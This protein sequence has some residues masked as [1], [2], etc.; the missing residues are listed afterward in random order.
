MDEDSRKSMTEQYYEFE[1]GCKIKQ[2]GTDIKPEDGL[3]PLEVDFYNIDYNCPKV[4]QLFEDGKTKGV[5]QLDKGLGP[6]WS[7]QTKPR[8]VE[9]IA[10]LTSILR[11][12]CLKSIVDGKSV[13]QRYADRKAGL[14]PVKYIH[15]SIEEV[16]RPTYGNLVFQEQSIHIAKIV[17]GF[18]LQQADTLRK[19]IGKK[20]ADTMAK[21]RKEFIEGCTKTGIVDDKIAVDIFDNIEKSNRYAFNKSH[22]VG[23][24]E[25]SYWTAY[26]KVHFPIHFYAAWLDMSGEKINPKEEVSELVEDAKMFNVGIYPPLIDHENF[27]IT[28]TGVHFGLKQ[29]KGIGGSSVTKLLSAVI[30]SQNQL[31]KNIKDWTWF[32]LLVFLSEK[33]SKTVFNNLVSLGVISPAGMSRQ[34]MLHEYSLWYKLSD[35]EKRIIVENSG[36]FLGGL[37]YLIHNEKVSVKRRDVILSINESLR[38]P[39]YSTEDTPHWITAI[40]EEL[41][42]TPITCTKVDNINTSISDSTCQEFING[43]SE[44]EM[45]FGVEICRASEYIIKSGPNAGK[46]MAF[47]TVRDNSG[48][49]DATIFNSLWAKVKNVAYKGNTCLITGYRSDKGGLIIKTIREI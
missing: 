11:P 17:A 49:M 20:E 40:E 31:G 12:G 35:K 32:E 48:S 46:P 21:V 45:T 24:S 28:K 39:P 38:E 42:G 19:A 43:K 6:H 26:L 44:K 10:A 33:I 27:T 16:L 37:R 22:A 7:K 9:E 23:Y 18:S 47:L 13:T 8:D 29:I 14:E 36:D 25:I 5:F 1:C 34:A 15:E 3:P 30:E 41:L 4:W 2:I